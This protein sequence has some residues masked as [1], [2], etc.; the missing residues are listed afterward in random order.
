MSDQ[1]GLLACF[2]RIP[3]IFL[4]PGVL[5][6]DEAASLIAKAEE[7]GFELQTSRGPAFGEAL[8]CLGSKG[9]RTGRVW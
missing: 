2:A 6:A 1:S 7:S 8:R 4:V 3:N 9:S 5:D